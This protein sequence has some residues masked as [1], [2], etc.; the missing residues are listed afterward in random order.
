MNH[1]GKRQSDNKKGKSKV[2]INENSKRKKQ[3]HTKA[4]HE[5]TLGGITVKKRTN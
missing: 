5:E 3:K 4:R 2:Q 1:E